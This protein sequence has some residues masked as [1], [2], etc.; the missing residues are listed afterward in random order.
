M[1]ITLDNKYIFKGEIKKA[2]GAA[3]GIES[4]SECI[5][6]TIDDNILK[7]IE[8]YDVIA[9]QINTEESQPLVYYL[10]LFFSLLFS[11]FVY[12]YLFCL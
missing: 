8:R 12:F 10:S 6:F 9:K 5:L 3:L 2:P 1:E 4:C 7:L 11:S